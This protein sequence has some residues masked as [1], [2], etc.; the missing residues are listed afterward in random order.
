MTDLQIDGVNAKSCRT[1]NVTCAD[2]TQK[3]VTFRSAKLHTGEFIMTCEDIT[4]QIRGEQDGK[5]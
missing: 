4:E 5:I 2:G 3:S 1:F